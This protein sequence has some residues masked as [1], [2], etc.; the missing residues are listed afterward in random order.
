MFK[1]ATLR[2]GMCEDVAEDAGMKDSD[3]GKVFLLKV[4]S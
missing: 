4:L 3:A 2:W 1:L